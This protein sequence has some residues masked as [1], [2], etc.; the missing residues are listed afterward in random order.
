[1]YRYGTAV[2]GIRGIHYRKASSLAEDRPRMGDGLSTFRSCTWSDGPA[3]GPTNDLV[4]LPLDVK[5]A[6]CREE[7]WASGQEDTKGRK[8]SRDVGR[9][10]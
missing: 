10:W 8:R 1:M 9:D 7:E 2:P 3:P 5:R 6:P 4:I